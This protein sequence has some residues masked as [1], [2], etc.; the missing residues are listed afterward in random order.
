MKIIF[1]ILSLALSFILSSNILYTKGGPRQHLL[2]DDNW[3]FILSDIKDA[4]K[5]NFDDSQWRTLNL[6]HDWSIEGEF[7]E[8]ATTNG[9]GGYL[10]AGIGWYRKHFSISKIQKDQNYWIQFDGVY[11]NSDVWINGQHLGKHV[12][13]YTSFYYDLTPFI[14]KG[15]NIIAVRVDNSLQPNSRWYSG[16]GIYRHVWLNIAEPVHI[17]QWGTYITTPS[18]D[19]ASATILVRTSI[20]NTLATAK[21]IIL[22][23][24]IRNDSGK[25]IA[26]VEVPVSISPSGTT[27]VEQTL[28]VTAPLLWSTETPHLYTLKS[29][30]LEGK[31]INDL[32]IT[33]FGIRE[34]AYDKDKGFLLNGKQVKMNGVCLHHDA[35]CLGAAVPEQAWVRR[36]QLLKEMGCNAIRTS[37]NPP[38]P[39]FLDLCDKMGFLVMDEAFDELKIAK[40]DVTCGYNMYFDECSQSDLI[41]MI[42]RDR[43]HPSVVIWSAGNEVPEQGKD[44]GVEVLQKLIETFHMEDPTRPVTVANDHIADEVYPAKLPFLENQDIVGY[45]YVD[46]WLKRRELYYSVDRH[47]HPDWKMIGTENVSARGIRGQYNLVNKEAL[48]G[49]SNDYR[50]NMVRAEQLWKFTSTYDYVI[51]DFMWTGIDYLGEANWPNKSSNAGVIDLCGFPKDSYYFYQSQWTRNPMVHLFPHWNWE[52]HEGQVIQVIAYTNCDSAEL[53]VNGKSFGIKSVVFPQQG[54][55]GGWNKYAHPFINATT[56]DLHLTWDVPYEPGILK[57]IARKDGIIVTE[58]IRTTSKPEAIRL[59]ADRTKFNADAQEIINV[60]AEVIDENG[61]VVPDADN[62]IEFKVEGEGILAGT[63]NGNPQDKTNMKSKQRNAFNGLALAVIQSNGK[64][65]DIRLT[66]ISEGL[67]TATIEIVSNKPLPKGKY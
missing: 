32:L 40:G 59:S 2:M 23:S 38:A 11:M 67:K 31:K 63:D 48:P 8:D 65:G 56:A 47:D 50:S 9:H 22:R 16:S 4:E 29:S 18:V 55:S 51:G 42:R 21:T 20:E 66:A 24:V 34:I 52:G 39:E 7:K 19:S 53:F 6:P 3:K 60:K 5:Q 33:S 45:N 35:G 26:M 14:K 10:P 64:I 28:K 36:L 30:I 12:Y 57:I 1:I 17:A 58:E 54:N 44:T 46:R 41:S 49:R 27:A 25:E 43:N 15:E 61:L 62:L 37:H 13:G